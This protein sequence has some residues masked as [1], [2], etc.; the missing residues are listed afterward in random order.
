MADLTNAKIANTYKDLLQVNAETSNA[1]L[2]GTLRTIQDGGGTASPIAMSTAQLNV[3]GQFALGG[4]VLTATADELNDLAD[5]GRLDT[6][7]AGDDTV[8]ITVGGVS[9]STATVSATVVVN[10]VLSLTEVDAATGSFNTQVSATNFIAGTG[11]FTTKVS[12]VA[13]EFSGNVSAANVYASTN[14]FV[15]GTAV[16]SAAAITSINTVIAAVSALTSVNKAAITSI[17]A[18]PASTFDALAVKTS[19]TVGPDTG[20]TKTININSSDGVASLEIGG[21]TATFVDLKTP[22]SDDY[23]LRIATPR[24][25]GA[26]GGYIETA[27]GGTFEVRGPGPE[28]LATFTDDGSVAL[29]HNNVKKLE[30]A[31]DGV[32]VDD[33]NLNGKV[34]TIT[35]D[36]GDTFT[37]TTGAAGETTLATTDAAGTDGKIILDADGLIVID[38]GSG[39]GGGDVHFKAGGTHYATINKSGDHA[40][41]VNQI[42]DGN[43]NLR[44]NDGG[45]FINALTLDMSEG[46][47]ATFN[48]DIIIKDGGTIGS[49]SDPDAI[50]IASDGVTTFSQGLTVSGGSDGDALLTFSIDRA[51][52]FL[53]SGDDASTSLVLKSLVDGKNFEIANSNGDVDFRFFTS[54]AGGDP[55]LQLQQ[56]VDIRFEGSTNDTNRTVLT[57]IDPTANRTISL[58]DETGT[59]HTSGGSITIPDGGTIG[60]ASDTDA[61]TIAADGAVTFNSSATVDDI[62]LN[63]KVLTITGDTDDTFKITTGGS[64]A[65]TLSTIDTAGNNGRITLDAD[66]YIELDSGGQYGQV[67]LDIGGVNYGEFF[68][69]GTNFNIRSNVNNGD[70]ILAGIDDG[71]YINVLR[72]DMSEAGKA[73]FIAGATFADDVTVE[74]INLSGKVLTITGD[75]GDTFTITSGANGATTLATVDTAGAAAD[76]TLN[77]DGH[78]ILNSGDNFGAV[79]FKR[80]GGTTY[81][82]F[83]T[84]DSTAGTLYLRNNNSDADIKI[85]GNDGGSFFTALTLDM[86]AAGAATFNNDVNAAWGDDRFVRMFFDASYHMG[87]HME[88]DTRDLVLYTKSADNAGDIRFKTGSAPTERMTI[89]ADGKVG[90]GTATPVTE[91]QIETELNAMS[92]TNVDV[93]NLA[94][95]I[96]NPQNDVGEAVGIGFALSTGADNVGAAITHERTGTDSQGKLHFATK[97]AAGVAADIPI[98]MTIDPDGKVGIGTT[99]PLKTLHVDGPALSTVQTLTD[100]STVTSDFDVGQNFTLTLGGNRTL[101]APSN[102]D[103]GQVGSIFIIQDGTGSRTLAYNSIWKFAGGTAPTLSTAAGA[104][105]RLDY[106]VQSGTAIQALLTKA[107][108]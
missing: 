39:T 47:T 26:A 66:G 108:A 84:D 100:A 60:S 70:I 52:A 17:N 79:D 64:G 53:Q 27:S 58:P 97:G 61:I 33:I 83:F 2:D 32:D 42:S 82:S 106:I 13:A 55:Q 92:G 16:P 41:F 22:F 15:G 69:G 105:D 50:Q 63:G 93:S 9:V 14:I 74:D 37:I 77:P 43:I 57:V 99:S 96:L 81:A 67:F 31:A 65:T 19:I 76:L 51:W 68:T 94:Q 88:A 90:I 12:G 48:D 45:S 23:D 38:S 6:L 11:S 89:L 18:G 103:A 4:T 95:K 46:G 7:T 8:K 86:S 62:N 49:A 80:Q 21:A 3:T 85:A 56:D 72:L 36:T 102:V 78:I 25:G 20:G 104:I 10:P 29:Y 5:A 30:T 91:F 35:G 73:I 107:Y 28:T 44:G 87:M 98:R 54:H 101:G 75:T 1:G 34:L 24:S 59:I 40:Y 71:S